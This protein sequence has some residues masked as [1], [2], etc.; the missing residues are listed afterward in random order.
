[1]PVQ[2]LHPSRLTSEPVLYL[3]QGSAAHTQLTGQLQSTTCFEYRPKNG[4]TLLN[5]WGRGESKE[6]RF[7]T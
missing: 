5:G 1:M 4:V 6:E 7:V 2:G 3:A